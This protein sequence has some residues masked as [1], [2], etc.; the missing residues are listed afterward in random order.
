MREKDALYLDG[1]LIKVR[2]QN[3]VSFLAW[4]PLYLQSSPAP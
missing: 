2:R 3:L 4:D 1:L